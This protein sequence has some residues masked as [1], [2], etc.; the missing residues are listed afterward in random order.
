MGRDFAPADF[1]TEPQP[2]PPPCVEPPPHDPDFGDAFDS[3][4]YT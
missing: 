2:A 4:D 3:D 1:A